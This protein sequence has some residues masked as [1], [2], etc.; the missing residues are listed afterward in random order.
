MNNIKSDFSQH[1][2]S[3]VNIFL[4]SLT[5]LMT[6]NRKQVECKVHFFYINERYI[7]CKC[8]KYFGQH[9]IIP[10]V[11]ISTLLLSTVE[12]HIFQNL[13][14]AQTKLATLA[15]YH[16]MLYIPAQ[17]CYKRYTLAFVKKNM[18]SC[19]ADIFN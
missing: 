13:Q 19:T 9:L 15:C 3:F 7:Q 5:I 2:W 12:L 1:S 18:I 16:N 14:L 4:Y 11:N 8:E 17:F 6:E 10:S